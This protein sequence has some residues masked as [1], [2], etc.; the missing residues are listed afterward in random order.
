MKSRYSNEFHAVSFYFMI[1]VR[2][3][4]IASVVLGIGKT[5]I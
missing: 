3:T 2:I 5:T 4:S 1:L